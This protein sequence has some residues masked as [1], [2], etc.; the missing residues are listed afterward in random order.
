MSLLLFNFIRLYINV[1]HCIA[2]HCIVL[3]C[4]VFRRPLSEIVQ[5]ILR[6]E[7]V[8]IKHNY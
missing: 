7:K 2:M 5:V 4:I 1:L 6:R 3:Y 8:F